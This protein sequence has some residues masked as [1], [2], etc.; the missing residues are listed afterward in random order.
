MTRR[1]NTRNLQKPTEPGTHVSTAPGVRVNGISEAVGSRE[2]V[3]RAAQRLADFLERDLDYHEKEGT[4]HLWGGE[5]G[6][7]ATRGRSRR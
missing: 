1:R 6:H 5:Q 7:P 2:S 4:P 3:H